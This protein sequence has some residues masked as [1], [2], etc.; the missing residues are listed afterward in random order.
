MILRI[1]WTDRY[2]RQAIGKSTTLGLRQ[3]LAKQFD[4][5]VEVI[6]KI[7]SI[8]HNQHG[9]RRRRRFRTISLKSIQRSVKQR[10]RQRGVPIEKRPRGH[11]RK[12]ARTSK[13]NAGAP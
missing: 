10:L 12:T 9:Q 3:R 6:K 11:P 13:E 5:S 2:Q 7:I 8:K 1:Y 4:V